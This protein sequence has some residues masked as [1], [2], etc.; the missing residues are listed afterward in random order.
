MLGKSLLTKRGLVTGVR[1]ALGRFGAVEGASLTVYKTGDM[2]GGTA[3]PRCSGDSSGRWSETVLTSFSQGVDGP[4]RFRVSEDSVHVLN[5]GHNRSSVVS[6]LEEEGGGG[7]LCA[8]RAEVIV[9]P[10]RFGDICSGEE[11]ERMSSK[12]VR[13]VVWALLR[14]LCEAVGERAT[15]SEGGS[16]GDTR[17]LHLAPFAEVLVFILPPRLDC[18]ACWRR[19]FRRRGLSC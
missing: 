8:L 6:S 18:G 15:G 2:V 13:L 19:W 14:L 17:L 16:Q 12:V 1:N 10:A 5:V 4:E 7:V 3:F 11:L 9:F